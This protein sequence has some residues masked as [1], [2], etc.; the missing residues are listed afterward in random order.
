MA[1]DFNA[2]SDGTYTLQ[3]SDENPNQFYFY[4]N[5]EGVLK[6][7]DREPMDLYHAFIMQK[8][9]DGEITG[10]V[11]NN[12]CEEMSDDGTTIRL[13]VSDIGENSAPRKDST[14]N[15][16]PGFFKRLFQKLFG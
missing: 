10:M 16:K 5:D 15:K 7:I 3:Q 8:M 2:V 6:D 13:T 1:N 9:F 14:V 4:R 11:M 12:I